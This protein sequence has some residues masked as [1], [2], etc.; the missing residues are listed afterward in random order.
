MRDIPRI[1]E[2]LQMRGDG[3]PA[4]DIARYMDEEACDIEAILKRAEEVGMTL[5]IPRYLHD[6]NL[7]W[8]L[9]PSNDLVFLPDELIFP[10]IP[11]PE[12]DR[13]PMEID[14][15]CAN[16]YNEIEDDSRE[17]DGYEK[18]SKMQRDY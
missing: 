1:R 11:E 8:I 4:E 13:E 9:F 3:Y 18:Y 10:L 6:M 7:Y 2:I 12:R 16:Y 14:E 17:D 5:P 15:D